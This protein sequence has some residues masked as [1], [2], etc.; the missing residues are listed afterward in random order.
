MYDPTCIFCKIIQ[1]AIPSK[2][3]YED[4]HCYA[5][6]DI[7]P[8]EIGHTLVVPKLHAELLTDLTREQL[9][10]LI[11]ATR[12]IA[13]NLL[14]KLPCD[15]FNLLQNN[16][17]C[18]TQ[19]VPHVHFHVIPRWNNTKLNWH[20]AEK[21]RSKEHMDEIHKRIALNG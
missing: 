11:W 10:N 6:M 4:E 8:F 18:A 5:F 21:Y 14:E 12:K 17:Q 1:G 7:A 3:V 19:T 20:S 15:G 16:G 2:V 13:G 9:S